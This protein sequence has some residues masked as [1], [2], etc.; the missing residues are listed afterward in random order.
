MR[1]LIEAVNEVSSRAPANILA[2]GKVPVDKS[3]PALGEREIWSFDDGHLMVI[4]VP[5]WALRAIRSFVDG[6]GPH[7]VTHYRQAGDVP[8]TTD[9]IVGGE[10]ASDDAA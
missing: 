4:R 2:R 3:N 9:P 8:A 6:P 5:A 1:R 7:H 10:V